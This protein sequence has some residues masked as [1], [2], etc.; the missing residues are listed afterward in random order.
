MTIAPI[1][2]SVLS[3]GRFRSW[4]ATHVGTVRTRNEDAFVNRPDLGLWAVADGAGGHQAGEVAAAMVTE[5]L[6]AVS[7]G[8]GAAQLLHEAR[9]RIFRAHDLLRAEAA[10]RGADAMLAT[11][12]VVLLARGDHYACL[13]AGD[14]RAYLLRRGRLIQVTHDHSLVQELVDAGTISAEDAAHHPR[15]NIITR[16][17]GAA[18]EPLDLDKISDRLQPG[19]RFLLCSDGLSKTVPQ[20]DL[21]DLLARAETPTEHLIS[22]ALER[23]VDDNVTAVA[24]E[25]LPNVA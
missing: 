1:A 6:G 8:L 13:W 20:G 14:S 24:V 16:A 23:R 18:G 2:A 25:V 17:V 21:A 22:A 19:D 4:A 9:A 7:G 5:A 3:A 15:A 11:T 10:R 12:V